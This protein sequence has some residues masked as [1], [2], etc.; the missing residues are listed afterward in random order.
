[1]ALVLSSSTLVIPVPVHPD[2]P[3]GLS[4]R[5]VQWPDANAA[6]RHRDLA[7]RM[8]CLDTANRDGGPGRS[9]GFPPGCPLPEERKRQ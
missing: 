8:R 7:G 4:T 1:M 9:T 2:S 6:R 5:T 3:L